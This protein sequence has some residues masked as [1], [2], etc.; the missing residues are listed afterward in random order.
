MPFQYIW[1]SD[2]AGE[3]ATLAFYILTGLYFRP[4]S[5][6]PYFAVRPPPS[7]GFSTAPLHSASSRSFHPNNTKATHVWDRLVGVLGII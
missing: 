7:K 2:A 4:H 6:N 1:V 5:Q 3:A